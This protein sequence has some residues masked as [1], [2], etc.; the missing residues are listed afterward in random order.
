MVVAGISSMLVAIKPILIRYTWLWM[1]ALHKM[2]WP[3]GMILLIEVY[4]WFVIVI[5]LLLNGI[6]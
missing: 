4:E 3:R 1:T 2:D 5:F 6:V